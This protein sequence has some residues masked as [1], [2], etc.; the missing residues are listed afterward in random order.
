MLSGII[1]TAVPKNDLCQKWIKI[2]SNHQKRRTICPVMSTR[3][4]EN[5]QPGMKSATGP[6]ASTC[7]AVVG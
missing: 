7:G 6:L 1:A 5:R 2:R 3:V 4:L